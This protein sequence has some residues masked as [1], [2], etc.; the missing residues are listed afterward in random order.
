MIYKPSEFA[1]KIGIS[2]ITLQRW[3][4]TGVLLA[5]RTPTNRRFYTEE[6]LL[7]YLQ[8]AERRGKYDAVET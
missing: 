8:N 5:N 1:E 4:K 2:V 7:E 6:Q 3:D